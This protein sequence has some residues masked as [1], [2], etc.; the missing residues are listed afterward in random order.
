[1]N[2]LQRL[3]DAMAGA[4]V[5]ALLV[6]DPANIRWLSGFHGSAGTVYVPLDDEPVLVTDGRYVERAAD[7]APGWTVIEDRTW[8]WLPERHDPSRDLGVEAD[9]LTWAA[10]RTLQDLD[11]GFGLQ[12]TTGLVATL[13]QTKDDAEIALLRRACTI[14]TDAFHDALG[15]LRPG[16]T[17]SQVARR[18]GDVMVD[19][20]AEGH[21]FAPI[22]ASGPNGSRPHHDTGDRVLADGDLVT[23]DF[24]ALVE[25]YHADMTRTVALGSPAAALV[26]LHELVHAAQQAGV[27]VARAGTA[28]SD[29]DR[30]CR[31]VITRAGHG[32]HFTHGTGHGVGLVIHETPFLAS[33]SPGTLQG[34]M[35]VTVEP[36]VY[37]PGL[38]GVRIEDV[39]LVGDTDAERL[40]T[41]PRQLITL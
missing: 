9:H 10:V 22:V 11:S 37:V 27:E 13:R 19:M 31:E 16:L 15:W 23:M 26:E 2:R 1:M 35:T 32:A 38:G 7:E 8:G 34:R 12:P 29:V 6:T 40:T 33:S 28:T 3:R 39:V 20:G 14:T 30:A 36:G 18:L 25:G 41:A 4:D 21:A 5:G 24:G 17:E